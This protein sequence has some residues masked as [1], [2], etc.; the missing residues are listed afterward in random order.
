MGLG[1]VARAAESLAPCLQHEGRI[2]PLVERDE[3]PLKNGSGAD[4]EPL[5][6]PSAI[7]AALALVPRH[8]PALWYPCELLHILTV[9]V[10]KAHAILSPDPLDMR[11]GAVLVREHLKE[12]K[13]ADDALTFNLRW[14]VVPP[15]NEKATAQCGGPK[16]TCFD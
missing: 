13:N 9:A 7:V 3:R 8:P 11:T 10:G 14:H 15:L 16:R 12:I 6:A 2:R 4:L 1:S 5:L